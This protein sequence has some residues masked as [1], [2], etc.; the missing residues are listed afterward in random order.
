MGDERGDARSFDACAAAA[1]EE[2][3]GKEDGEK[4]RGEGKRG[5]RVGKEKGRDWNK[6]EAVRGSEGDEG[7]ER[8]GER[9]GGMK[10][11]R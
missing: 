6:R 10:G 4:R 1:E 8:R 7:K 3:K 9:D 11:K 5:K 2:G